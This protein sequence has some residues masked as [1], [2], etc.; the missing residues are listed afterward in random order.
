MRTAGGW[1]VDLI[2]R[3]KGAG[4]PWVAFDAGS[5][6]A[7]CGRRTEQACR[8]GNGRAGRVRIANGTGSMASGRAHGL[9]ADRLPRSTAFSRRLVT[10]DSVVD[11]PEQSDRPT[12]TRRSNDGRSGRAG[13]CRLRRVGSNPPAGAARRRRTRFPGIPSRRPI[14]SRARREAS[15]P[16][17]P[18]ARTAPDPGASPASRRGKPAY[19]LPAP[20]RKGWSG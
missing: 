14:S 3:R 19:R 17:R 2:G 4:P 12:R 8:P 15:P 13:P 7:P 10:D 11:A 9:R 5:R 16:I 6:P 18:G 20:H 1:Q